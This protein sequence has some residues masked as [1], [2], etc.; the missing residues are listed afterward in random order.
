MRRL[1]R[2]FAREE[3]IAM[4]TVVLMIAVLTLLGVVL[5]DQVTA[6]SQRSARAVKS[7]AVYQAAEAGINDYIAKLLDDPQFYDHFVAKGEST[8]ERS[9]THALVPP[10]TDTTPSLWTASVGWTYPN[11]KDTWFRGTGST[12]VLEGYAYNLMVS[13]P[14]STGTTPRNYAT[15]VSTGCR[16]NSAGSA[17]DTRIAERAIEVH[18]RRSTPADFFVMF[19]EDQ[20]FG[21]GYT[22]YGPIY[23]NGDICHDGIAY[24]DIM[25]EGTI[26]NS[27]HCGSVSV[28]LRG[29]PLARKLTRPDHTLDPVIKNPI[30]FSS[31]AVSLVDLKAAAQQNTPS[32]YF[33]VSGTTAWAFVFRSDG[34]Y[35]LKRCTGSG[36]P[37]GTAP[38]S[39][40]T[41]TGSPFNIPANG[42][43]FTNQTAVISY[44]SESF[45]NGRVTIAS[46]NNIVIGNDIHYAFEPANTGDDVLGLIANNN[47]YVAYYVPSVLQWRAAVIA[48][49]G[50]RKS[51]TCPSEG[52]GPKDTVTFRG[53]VSSN[54]SGCMTMF[55]TRNNYA[56]DTLKYLF[57]PWYPIID[58]AET[59]VLFREVPPSHTPPAATG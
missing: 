7:D 34:K 19:N 15:V 13:P 27:S 4:V 43:I 52:S 10:S 51:Y 39:C 14:V 25:A 31:F 46:S 32:S 20:N 49:N 42:A 18:V 6:E 47:V 40:T 33:N 2:F 58:G 22:N 23:V 57:P 5:I 41:Y 48:E 56:D 53:S 45:V 21:T 11:G 30:S 9:D 8:R 35:D 3:G 44:P 59:T 38:S 28:E 16:L 50:A 36:D 12:T 37:G 29:T 54:Q 26:N 17:C 1:E 55:D 24:G